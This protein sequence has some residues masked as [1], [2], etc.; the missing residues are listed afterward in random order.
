MNS[1]FMRST[2]S[3]LIS[4]QP[5]PVL[6]SLQTSFAQDNIRSQK[7]SAHK[8]PICPRELEAI[9]GSQPYFFRSRSPETG[10]HHEYMN[11]GI[12]SV[13]KLSFTMIAID[14][15]TRQEVRGPTL[16]TMLNF[17]VDFP[18][19]DVAQVLKHVQYRP[20][21]FFLSESLKSKGP[22]IFPL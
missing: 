9:R 21:N 22:S 20:G 8:A 19:V 6:S 5:R 17:L 2:T 13:C 11:K 15:I 1:L 10:I 18:G 7:L 4:S 3:M 16:H 14:S 12:K